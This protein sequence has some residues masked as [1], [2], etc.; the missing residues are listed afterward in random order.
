[1]SARPGPGALAAVAVLGFA[2]AGAATAFERRMETRAHEREATL[3]AARVE[4][5]RVERARVRLESAPDR[6]SALA[7]SPDEVRVAILEAVETLSRSSRVAL[8]GHALRPMVPDPHGAGIGGAVSDGDGSG[9]ARDGSDA[10]VLRL[11]LELEAV[12]AVRLLDALAGLAD[13]LPGRPVDVA[14]CRV[15]RVPGRASASAAADGEAGPLV[16]S[17]ALDWHWWPA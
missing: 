15:E 1:M 8:L 7:A 17:C 9:G 5:Q 10:H 11:T 13:A 16:A 12:H 6:G 4:L 2:L 14:G 3:R